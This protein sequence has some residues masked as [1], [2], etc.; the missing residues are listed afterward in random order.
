[1]VLTYIHTHIHTYIHTH[2]HTHTYIHT[3]TA[4]TSTHSQVHVI[5]CWPLVQTQVLLASESAT[6]TAREGPSSYGRRRRSGRLHSLRRGAHD[7]V[8][9]RST[10]RRRGRVEGER[11]RGGRNSWYKLPPPCGDHSEEMSH[12]SNPSEWVS[13]E[14]LTL[15][16]ISK[17][18]NKNKI[19]FFFLLS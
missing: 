5:E 12:F 19:L 9:R 1:M 4:H 15:K 17:T 18:F 3:Y 8:S 16:V 10:D 6:P 11:G 14:I 13:E 2:T 7:W